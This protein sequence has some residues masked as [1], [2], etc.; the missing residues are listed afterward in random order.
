M[1]V[2]YRA[3]LV[4]YFQLFAQPLDLF[5]NKLRSVVV[6]EVSWNSVSSVDVRFKKFYYFERGDGRPMSHFDIEE[7]I[8]HRD[9]IF[10]L[11]NVGRELA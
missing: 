2:V 10:L 11:P 3:K 1:W 7:V 8:Y 4:I 6:Y 9:Y 5:S